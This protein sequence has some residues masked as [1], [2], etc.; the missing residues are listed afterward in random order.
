MK[1]I[2]I[3]TLA[4]AALILAMVALST[5]G[6]PK[7][8]ANPDGALTHSS[9]A[10]VGRYGIVADGVGLNGKDDSTEAEFRTI[11]LDVP[12]SVAKAYLY[13]AG[14]DSSSDPST[15]NSVSVA[16]DN[17]PTPT[18][19]IAG[20]TYGPAE[21]ASSF[22]HFVFIADV[23]SLVQTGNHEYAI[24][25]AGL[26]FIENY[27]AGLMVVYEDAGLPLS[28]IVIKDGLDSFHCEY[29]VPQG[30]D[31]EVTYFDFASDANDRN[32][33]ITLF[34]GGV[35]NENRP[36]SLWYQT[37]SKTKPSKL[38]DKT[39][40]TELTDYLS[41]Y[42]LVAGDEACWDTFASGL[43]I[44]VPAGDTWLG[45][46]LE[47][48]CD[49]SSETGCEALFMA[50]GM[51]I[52]GIGN[53][54]TTTGDYI[55]CT[56]KRD[57]A[58][59]E[60]VHISGG[61]F[62]AGVELT[63]KVI[64][65]DSSVVTGDG[66]FVP[67]PNPYDTVTT[68]D[69]GNFEYAYVLDGIDG[70]YLVQVLDGSWD[71][72]PDTVLATHTFMDSPTWPHNEWYE[73]PGECIC[74]LADQGN[75][76]LDMVGCP[77]VFYDFNTSSGYAFFRQQ[78]LGDPGLPGSLKQNGWTVL[79]DTDD[80]GYYEV[81][82]GLNGQEIWFGGSK[83]ETVQVWQNTTETAPIVWAPSVFSD[84]PE[85]LVITYL[86]TT[87]SNVTF[88]SP[89]YLID[90]AVPISVLDSAGVSAGDTMYF[91]TS[92]DNNNWNKDHPEC[93]ECPNP[94]TANAGADQSDCEDSDGT[95]TFS[96]SGS[97]T[98]AGTYSYQWSTADAGVTI[99]S[100]DA[101]N[102]TVDI[103]GSGS[104]TITLKV[105]DTD[106]PIICYDYDD[107]VL[108]VYPDPG[109]DDGNDCTDDYRTGIL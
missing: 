44:T 53:H 18:T 61:G 37:G 108:T 100:P 105:T 4:A 39:K 48:V 40:A 17:D 55:V 95:T 51:V 8:H 59:G 16:V 97:A 19:I 41:T 86:A 96:L 2:I 26:T 25:G 90:W 99:N 98:G 34:A 91:A 10:A 32:V 85:T 106:H 81:L 24:S 64:R 35:E 3:P 87:N 92:A 9:F 70:E 36:N 22:Y 21:W 80:D 76:W 66:S 67:W 82:V 29:G 20:E 72:A 12:G 62:A 27:G 101:Q 1:R 60:T 93:Y 14:Y 77:C 57:Y 56:D 50:S 23:T 73:P 31:T 7:V 54:C 78:L 58:P 5:A 28:Y 46:Q 83:V 102:T 65:P 33:A 47:S 13:W 84:P 75:T 68:D 15:V 94:V 52:S 69:W 107:V 63:I 79:F 71:G 38:V 30:P 49:V 104:F 42:P 88:A 43:E 45:L 103:T 109:C 89:Y 74:D 11:Q 6:T